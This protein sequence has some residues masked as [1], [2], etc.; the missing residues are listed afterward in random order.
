M[1]RK[2]GRDG[3]QKFMAVCRFCKVYELSKVGKRL[4]GVCWKAFN[5]SGFSAPQWTRP[6]HEVS[7]C[8]KCSQ[9]KGR[10]AILA[11]GGEKVCPRC[12]TVKALSEYYT[13]HGLPSAYCKDCS[14]EYNK[15][16]YHES[17]KGVFTDRAE[18]TLYHLQ[19]NYSDQELVDMWDGGTVPKVP[20][21]VKAPKENFLRIKSKE[22][23]SFTLGFERG[24]GLASPGTNSQTD[25]SVDS[26]HREN[27]TH[28]NKEKKGKVRFKAKKAPR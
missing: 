13:Y 21:K 26:N 19:A 18:A 28:A 8:L 16:R 1:R 12:D 27:D 3:A 5:G 9:R 2:L 7:I 17:R 14:R 11:R 25:S 20:E 10:K 6:F 4:C 23:K 22:L 15:S 24:I